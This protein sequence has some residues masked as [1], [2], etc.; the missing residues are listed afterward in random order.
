MGGGGGGRGVGTNRL[1]VCSGYNVPT[2]FH[3]LQK[4]Y[5]TCR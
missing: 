4:R 2:I 1:V 3:N 5:V